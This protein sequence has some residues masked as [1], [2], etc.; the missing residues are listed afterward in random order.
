M[1]IMRIV[2]SEKVQAHKTYVTMTVFCRSKSAY[3]AILGKRLRRP[4]MT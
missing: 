3:W 1:R 4:L 2:T